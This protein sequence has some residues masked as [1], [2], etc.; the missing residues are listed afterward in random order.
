VNRWLAMLLSPIHGDG[1]LAPAHRRDLE[2][3]GITERSWISQGIRAVPPSAGDRLLGFQ[4]PAA[5][6]SLMLIPYPDPAGGYFDAFQVK[7]FPALADGDGHKV[8]YLQPWGSAPH[9]YF[10]REALAAV[11]DASRPLFLVEGAKK[12]IA[13]AQLGLPAV[14]FNGIQGW[15]VRGSRELLDDFDHIP[16]EGREVK[17]LP[18]GDVRTN[19]DVERGAARLAEAL[20][21]RGAHVRVVLLPTVLAA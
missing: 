12:A 10:V 7:L 21:A 19:P 20:E 3:S 6:T 4:I 11:M 13:A 8:K 15:H 18:D 17:I 2:N 1:A 5:V 14:G 9:L 16:L